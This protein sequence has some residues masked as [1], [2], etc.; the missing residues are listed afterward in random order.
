MLNHVFSIAPNVEKKPRASSVQPV[1][2]EKIET[3]SI[4]H[5]AVVLRI[6]T[7]IENREI[8]PSE[9]EAKSCTVDNT[10]DTQFS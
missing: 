4:C 8:N 3:G 2:A 1:E 6:A 7:A 5:A 9:I 10:I